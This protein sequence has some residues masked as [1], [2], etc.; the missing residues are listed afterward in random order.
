MNRRDFCRLTLTST[1]IGLFSKELFSAENNIPNVIFI[2]PGREDEAFWKDVS[3]TMSIASK[4]LGIQLTVIYGNRNRL[5]TEE[6]G[7]NAIN[8]APEGSYII[9]VN[10]QKTGYPLAS[11]ALKKGLKVVF[12]YNPLVASDPDDATLGTPRQPYRNYIGAVIPDNIQAGELIAQS[13]MNAATTIAPNE[14]WGIIGLGGLTATPAG[15]DRLAGLQGSLTGRSNFTLLQTTE[16]DWSEADAA[17][18]ALGLLDRYKT[19]KN[20]LIWCANDPIALGALKTARQA[21]RN[22][23]RDTLIAGLNWSES[24][25]AAIQGGDMIG[26][27][28]GH[29]FTGA[30]ALA[31]IA[32]HHAGLDFMSGGAVKAMPFSLIDKS[33]LGSLQARFGGNQ[34]AFDKIDYRALSRKFSGKAEYDLNPANLIR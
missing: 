16:T 13:L 9:L 2:N 23:G 15:A 18:R 3:T 29:I 5:K 20:L 32:D 7:K 25:F 22:I 11:E 12:A 1:A 31:L 10:E 33:S 14:P 21:G 4:L 28:G 6:L 24:A 19:H 27:V 30:T 26:S 34:I 17:R 8:S